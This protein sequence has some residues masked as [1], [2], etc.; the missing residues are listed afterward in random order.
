MRAPFLVQTSFVPYCR[1]QW[2]KKQKM[3][4][5]SIRAQRVVSCNEGS[6]LLARV[7]RESIFR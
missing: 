5:K 6:R 7:S 4:E 2:V 1:A 3:A